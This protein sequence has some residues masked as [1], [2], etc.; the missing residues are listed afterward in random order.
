MDEALEKESIDQKKIRNKERKSVWY[1][2]LAMA[3]CIGIGQQ[4]FGEVPG[5]F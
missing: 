5:L 2:F 3:L 1:L 4:V